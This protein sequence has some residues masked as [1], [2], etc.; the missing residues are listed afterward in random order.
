[1]FGTLAGAERSSISVWQPSIEQ[2][3]VEAPAVLGHQG[4]G[5]AD[6]ASRMHLETA[7]HTQGVGQSFLN[8]NIVFD[9]QNR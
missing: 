7:V 4:L 3:D 1:M 9:Q 6:A 8:E 2:E 5:L